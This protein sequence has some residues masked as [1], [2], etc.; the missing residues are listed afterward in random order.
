MLTKSRVVA[1]LSLSHSVS[2]C[3]SVLSVGTPFGKGKGKG[4]RAEPRR[5]EC[6]VVKE[7]WS[8]VEGVTGAWEDRERAGEGSATTA[9]IT[10]TVASRAK[11]TNRAAILFFSCFGVSAN[12]YKN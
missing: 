8:G 12:I 9:C 11:R 2:Q 1:Y 7:V 5:A 6:R 4:K 10:A 3:K